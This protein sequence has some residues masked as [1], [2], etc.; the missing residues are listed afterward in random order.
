MEAKVSEVLENILGLMALEGSFEVTEGPDE[1]LVSIETNDAGRL[2]GFK[3]ETLDALQFLVNLIANR[4]A[5]DNYKR[6]IVDVAGWRKSKEGDLERRARV[7]A[8]EVL[9]SGKEIELDPMPSWQRRIVHMVISDVEGVESE[10]QGEGRDR[11]LVIKPASA[12]ASAGKPAEKKSATKKKTTKTE[13]PEVSTKE[14]S[15]SAEVVD[16]TIGQA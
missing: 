11:H 9:Q 1:V 10:S 14:S 7:W 3:G 2:I 13:K 8:D 12:K 16:E 6:V 15:V 5:G 4:D